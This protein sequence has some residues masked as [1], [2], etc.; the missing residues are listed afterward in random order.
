ME[1]AKRVGW[2]D[3]L[4]GILILF[5]ILSHSYPAQVYRYFFTPFFLTLFFFAS[6][7]TFSTKKNTKAFLQ[8]KWKRLGIPFLVLGGIRVSINY[9]LYRDGSVKDYI[10]AFLLQKNSQGDELWF[11]SCLITTSILMYIV[12]KIIDFKVE[13]HQKKQIVFI[14]LVLLIAGMFDIQILKVKFL[15]QLEL[16]CV[17][18]FYMAL[19]FYYKEI[20]TIEILENRKFIFV[21]IILYMLIV[22]ST[23]NKVDVH[24]EKFQY[25]VIFFITSLLAVA[26]L[27]YIS[28]KICDTRLKPVLI[29]L[30]QNTLF[31]YAFAGIVRIVLYMA[32]QKFLSV[33]PDEYVMPVFCT[34]VSA[35]LLAY[36]AKL[37]KRYLPWIVG[38]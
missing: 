1:K 12:K 26:P 27:I 36:P 29:F 23:R 37:V 10:V 4:K 19:G 13:E 30:G 32:V 18:A 21:N 33:Q 8:N 35:I 17:M 7:Y 3:V 28:K 15:W 14:A 34:I 16:A 31:Y 38:C 9:L 6:G 25:P 24:L 20:K 22:M 5:V 2:L 11:V